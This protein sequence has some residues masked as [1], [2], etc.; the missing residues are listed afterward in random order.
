MTRLPGVS[1]SGNSRAKTFGSKVNTLSEHFGERGKHGK[2][3]LTRSRSAG[4]GLFPVLEGGAGEWEDKG[5]KPILYS[6]GDGGLLLGTW[7][8]RPL[9]SVRLQCAPVPPQ[10]GAL[11]PWGRG[12]VLKEAKRCGTVAGGL[13]WNQESRQDVSLILLLTC[14]A[15]SGS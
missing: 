4:W 1:H 14:S 9:L 6:L 3:L 8:L 5:Q 10:E 12:G 2:A 11:Q 13:V 7:Q 15:T